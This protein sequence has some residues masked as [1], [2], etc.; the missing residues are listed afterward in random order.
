[1]NEYVCPMCD[2]RTTDSNM[3]LCDVC[4]DTIERNMKEMLEE[5]E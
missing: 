4:K 5:W 2:I 3:D 1:M